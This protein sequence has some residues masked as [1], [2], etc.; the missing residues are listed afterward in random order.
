MYNIKKKKEKKE[1]FKRLTGWVF[2]FFLIH[3]N[4]RKM[5]ISYFEQFKK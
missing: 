4:Y 2:F 3:E 1:V 5:T